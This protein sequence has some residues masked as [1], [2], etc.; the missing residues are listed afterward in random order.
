MRAYLVL[1]SLEPLP[2][3]PKKL[4]YFFTVPESLSEFLNFSIGLSLTVKYGGF[5][6]SAWLGP[7]TLLGGFPWFLN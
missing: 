4:V 3:T 6:V 2:V 7:V 1:D 5:N